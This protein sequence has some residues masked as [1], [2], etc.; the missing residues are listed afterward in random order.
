MRDGSDAIDSIAAA[1]TSGVAGITGDER[2]DRVA[3]VCCRHRT[4]VPRMAADWQRT[5]DRTA[6]TLVA[7]E[8]PL[9][10]RILDYTYPVWNEGLDRDCVRAV[11]RGAVADPVGSPQSAAAGPGR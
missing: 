5:I 4:V 7:A 6:M 8:G 11:E 3:Q 2:P 10:D 9:L 1:R